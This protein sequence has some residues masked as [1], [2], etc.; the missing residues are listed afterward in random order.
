MCVC[1]N[2]C[3][4][5]RL[6]T[7][8]YSQL[9]GLGPLVGHPAAW[10][11]WCVTLLES[12]SYPHA[13][14]PPLWNKPTPLSRGRRRNR[15]HPQRKNGSNSKADREAQE[16]DRT[17]VSSSRPYPP[18]LTSVLSSQC[19]KNE[20]EGTQMNGNVQLLSA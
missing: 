10:N 14:S 13:R 5:K 17:D 19:R 2:L 8:Y 15:P 18:H 12:P 3:R 7:V 16:W 1:S 6:L 9:C 4:K 11:V 20:A